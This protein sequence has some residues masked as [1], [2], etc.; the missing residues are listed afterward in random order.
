MA[1]GI[2]QAGAEQHVRQLTDFA[3]FKLQRGGTWAD[4]DNAPVANAYAV[5]LEDD[6]CGFDG[7]QPGRQQ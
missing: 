4:K 7:Y 3:C 2:D 5:L 1:M 6:A